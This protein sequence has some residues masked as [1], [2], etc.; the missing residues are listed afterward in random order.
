MNKAITIKIEQ[1]A[2]QI[3]QE[4]TKLN[5]L[6]DEAGENGL[7]VTM[8]VLNAATIENPHR[9]FLNYQILYEL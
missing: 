5:Q 4:T 3:K 8:E 1:L 6:L 9:I 7:I 2:E